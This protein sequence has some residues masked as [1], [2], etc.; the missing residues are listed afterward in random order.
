MEH[1]RWEPAEDETELV[2]A[3]RFGDAAAFA[4]LYR[5][6]RSAARATAA[7]LRV[8]RS[9]RDDVVNQAFANILAA[10]RKGNGPVDQ[11]RPYLVIAVRNLVYN[12]TRQ[13]AKA[14]DSCRRLSNE[15]T[16]VPVVGSDDDARDEMRA[17]F[18]QLP[19]R[20]RQVLHIVEVEG[21]R[22]AEVAPELGL[23]PN[24]VAALTS[25]ARRGLRTAYLDELRRAEAI[26]A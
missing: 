20:W 26:S 6:H 21:R 2:T 9:D 15:R 1:G 13:A 3:A 17:A 12:L 23:S 24:A 5:R 16:N 19:E 11:F 18:E 7:A 22:P 10:F 25:R 4:E 8:P 14:D